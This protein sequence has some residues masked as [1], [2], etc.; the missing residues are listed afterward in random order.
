MPC[1]FRDT[2][3]HQLGCITERQRIGDADRQLSSQPQ[4]PDRKS[5]HIAAVDVVGHCR[6]GKQGPA[7]P[8]PDYSDQHIGGTD[9]AG[10]LAGELCIHQRGFDTLADCAWP[11]RQHKWSRRHFL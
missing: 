1:Y 6:P 9:L 8:G 5:N 4:V 3:F 2:V 7:N 11:A 10:E